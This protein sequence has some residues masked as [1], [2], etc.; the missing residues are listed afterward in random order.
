MKV[1]V[2]DIGTNSMRLLITDYENG[3]LNNS[4]KFINTTR[5][6]R[7]INR[8]GELSKETIE[9]NVEALEEFVNLAKQKGVKEIIASGTSALRD[10]SNSKDFVELAKKRVGINVQI[11]DGS[12]EARLGFFGTR[13]MLEKNAYNLIVDIGGGSTEFVLSNNNEEIIFSKSENIGAVRMSQCFL[14]NDP[15]LSTQVEEMEKEIYGVFKNTIDQIKKHPI[16]KVISIGGTATSMAS[17][18]LELK[19]YEPQKVHGYVIKMDVLEKMYENLKNMDL[20]NRQ[21]LTGL[22]PKRADVIIAGV[23]IMR[24][25]MSMLDFDSF[26]VSEYDNLEGMVYSRFSNN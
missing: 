26:Y 3:T 15:P 20:A 24:Q 13:P 10:S 18:A 22:Q 4:E 7:G 25:I 1:G 12:F 5:I 11:I 17:M 2:I 23:G 16:K 14:K 21:M 19:L 6:G 9:E 8:F